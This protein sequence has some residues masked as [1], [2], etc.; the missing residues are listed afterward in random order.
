[1]MKWRMQEFQVHRTETSGCP[2]LGGAPSGDQLLVQSGSSKAG[3]NL[4]WRN[5]VGGSLK[6]WL[7][8]TRRWSFGIP[9]LWCSRPIVSRANY[10]ELWACAW[11]F[12]NILTLTC[13]KLELKL[14][15]FKIL[16]LTRILE[17]YWKRYRLYN[18][19]YHLYNGGR[20]LSPCIDEPAY[21]R[22]LFVGAAT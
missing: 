14:P 5:R 4:E 10:S 8:A 11:A 9:V 15:I 16:T 21:I 1:M 12:A 20:G 13:C 7:F 18:P 22:Q 19:S 17:S 2:G 6:A 3:K